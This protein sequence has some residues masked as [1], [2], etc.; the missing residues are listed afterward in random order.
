M[1]KIISDLNFK[2]INDIVSTIDT[3]AYINKMFSTVKDLLISTYTSK[4]VVVLK[5][6]NCG[7]TTALVFRA[8]MEILSNLMKGENSKMIKIAVVDHNSGSS[9]SKNS[10]FLTMLSLLFGE[11]IK[12]DVMTKRC[13]MSKEYKFAIYF[14]SSNFKDYIPSY[15]DLCLFDEYFIFSEYN[16]F[17]SEKKQ[18]NKITEDTKLF[19]VQ[20]VGLI[21]HIKDAFDK[22]VDVKILTKE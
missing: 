11:N 4:H 12:Y 2:L 16:K 5:N 20:T 6:R 22:N 9:A 17:M 13:L 7:G 19:M 1:K 18:A 3:N 14:T 21:G 10:M 8:L 15:L